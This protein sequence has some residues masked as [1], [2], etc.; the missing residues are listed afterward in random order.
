MEYSN[1]VRPYILEWHNEVFL[2]AFNDK[3]D[4]ENND[5]NGIGIGIATKDLVDATFRIKKR[6]FSTQQ[7]YENYIVPLINAGYVDKI[8]NK[9]DR[10]SYLFYPVLN[11]KQKNYSMWLNRIIYHN[12]RL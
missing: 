1:G 10:R 11:A 9:K 3:R 2:I 5:E 4:N 6:K 12:K 7:I 8:E